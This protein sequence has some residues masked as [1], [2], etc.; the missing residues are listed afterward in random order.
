MNRK[1]VRLRSNFFAHWRKCLVSQLA[2]FV[3]LVGT[4]PVEPAHGQSFE[5][6]QLSCEYLTDPLAVSTTRPR[7]SWQLEPCQ[8]E[9][10]GSIQIAYQIRVASN[11]EL[12]ESSQPDLWDSGRVESARTLLVEY[13][14]KELESGQ[15]CFWQVRVWDE[16]SQPSE[17]SSVATWRVGLLA[18]HDWRGEW[19]GAVNDHE[20]KTANQFYRREFEISDQC[21]DGVIYIASFGYHEVM[22]NGQRL[23]EAVLS[24]A[25][26]D[27]MNRVRYVAYDASSFLRDGRNTLCVTL[28]AGWTLYSGIDLWPKRPSMLVQGIFRDVKGKQLAEIHTDR[29]WKTHPANLQP[30]A[31]W[32]FGN[33]NGERQVANPLSVE[34]CQLDF[35][36]THWSSAEPREIDLQFQITAQEVEANKL[37]SAIAARSIQQTARDTYRVAMEQMF[38]G[39]LDI[40]LSG[41]ART[42]VTIEISDRADVSCSYGQRQEI[43]LGEKGR[44]RFRNRF[45]Y[46][47]G[48][49]LTI[50]GQIDPPALTDI[51]A[52]MVSTELTRVGRFRCS[53]PFHN[54]L[55]DTSLHTLECLNL[56]GYI[57]D[58]AHRERLGYGGDGKPHR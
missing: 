43:R 16:H 31:R 8:P 39:F 50:R 51:S 49:W 10:R 30:L 42:T 12:L 33:F 58:C 15:A 27:S 38:T 14:G 17:W 52:H 34:W 9:V 32:Q 3:V 40:R 7:L 46:A 4:A 45:N 56:G 55:Y 23:S 37:G 26:S 18:S 29:K 11:A 1:I 21:T 13:S 53:D 24:P 44:A 25:I 6:T 57:V 20:L 28:G 19:I 22:F 47:C 41:R 5:P 48:Q 35:D 54:H 36:A 2:I